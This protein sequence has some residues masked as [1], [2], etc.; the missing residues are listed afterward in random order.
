MYNTYQGIEADNNK[1]KVK[2]DDFEILAKENGVL[3]CNKFYDSE[4]FK[5]NFKILREMQED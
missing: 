4:Y 1:I 2:K 3:Q 5:K